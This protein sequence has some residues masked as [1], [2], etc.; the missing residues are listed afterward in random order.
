LA[1]EKNISQTRLVSGA[2]R[3]QPITMMV[4]QGA[5]ALAALAVQKKVTPR[6]VKVEDVQR[7][8]VN[9]GAVLSQY[10]FTDMPAI[11]TPQWQAVQLVSA[12]GM[13]A[14]TG[15]ETFGINDILTRGQAAIA[16]ARRFNLETSESDSSFT[17]VPSGTPEAAA[18]EALYKAGLTAGCSK[19]P[20]KFC[21]NGPITRGQ[22]IVFLAA[23]MGAGNATVSQKPYFED[24]PATHPFFKFVQYAFKHGWTAGCSTNPRNFCPDNKV[25]R[26]AA[27]LFIAASLSE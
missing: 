22:F 8:L 14:G 16:I 26:I 25:S 7:V 1:A 17:D 12:R 24:V 23:G 19:D 18:I 21:P 6:E 20:L 9:A 10:S 5:G 3:L 2:T 27:A 15:N 11:G 4:G 13:L